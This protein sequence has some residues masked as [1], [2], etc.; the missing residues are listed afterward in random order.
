[1]IDNP[2]TR[3]K[4]QLEK[5]A[6][7]IKLDPL[8]LTILSEPDRISEFSIPIK[9]DSGDVKSYTG[10]RAQHND[11]LGP[12]KGGLRYHPQ[13]SMDEVKALA[14]WM[15]I[16]NA[17]IDVPFGGGKGGVIV[18]PKSLSEAEL[19]RLTLEF[20]RKLFPL[21]GPYL[22]VPAPDVNTNPKIMGWIVEEYQKIADGHTSLKLRGAGEGQ[23]AKGKRRNELSAVVTG[24]PLDM[25][26]SEGRTE[27]TGL[28]GVYA[29]LAVLRKL[30]I[31]HRN[32]SVAIQG[33]GNVGMF[34]AKFLQLEGFNIVAVSDS[35]GGIFIP[36]GVPDIDLIQNYKK[37]Q[38]MLAGCYCVGSVCDVRY[39]NKVEGKDL[40]PEE[41]LELPVDIIIPAALENVLTKETARKVKARYVLEMANGP[42]TDEAD[43]ILKK[44]GIT[45]IPDVL[46]NSGGV[47]TSYFEW[48]QNIHGEKW[49]AEKVF[50]RLKEKMERAV[51]EV[52]NASIKFNV[53]FRDA[54]YIVALQRIEKK[55]IK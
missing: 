33:F 12:Y 35:K 1:M 42:T 31:N 20:T 40:E 30:G 23:M 49:T 13:V 14:F 8:L 37:E 41:L 44:R 5:T 24:K 45:V 55:F 26:G 11:L 19:K 18:N 29:L 4:H 51:D 43:E 54:A 27:A 28:G 7:L 9:L 22:D 21:I 34:I 36:S 32:M 38:G 17:V 50:K 39:K 16:K 6:S 46:A 48:Y 25:N 10:F 2:W 3:A 47:A 52:Y 53:T 15:T